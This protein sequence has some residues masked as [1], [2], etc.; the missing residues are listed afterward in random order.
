MRI[1]EDPSQMIDFA[2]LLRLKRVERRLVLARGVKTTLHPEPLQKIGK[3]EAACDDA[4][5]ADNRVFVRP[6]L[7]AGGKQPIAAGSRDILGEGINRQAVLGG[8]RAEFGARSA[9]IAPAIRPAS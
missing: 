3:A 5:R 6:N 7:V 8:Q 9:P 2:G 4:D 1:L